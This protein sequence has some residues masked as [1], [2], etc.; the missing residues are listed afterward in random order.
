[1][2]ALDT[3]A[4][5]LAT[6]A[7]A[8]AIAPPAQAA[9]L[10]AEDEELPA[11]AALA[12]PAELEGAEM[13]APDAAAPALARDAEAE[14]AMGCYSEEEDSC[15]RVERLDEEGGAGEP[16]AKGTGAATAAA[17]SKHPQV[18]T[19]QQ[20]PGRGK[21]KGRGKNSL[22][23]QCKGCWQLFAPEQMPVGHEFCW[24]DK[25]AL[26][27]IYNACKAQQQHD[28]WKEHRFNDHTRTTML[29]RC[30]QLHP[31]YATRRWRRAAAP[32]LPRATTRGRAAGN[33]A[34]ATVRSMS[35]CTR[36][37]SRPRRR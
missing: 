20:K 1:M 32:G 17:A 3:A 27:N 6:A 18:D 25:R 23:I 15:Y 12:K 5:A 16:K 19:S 4:R 8:L 26:D 30:H 36:R 33:V 34:P 13:A 37:S 28:F 2:A 21:G 24:P 31:S 7:P 35:S 10:L 14:A 9:E 11:T 22:K 29:K